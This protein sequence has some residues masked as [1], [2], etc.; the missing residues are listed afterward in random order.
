[1]VTQMQITINDL[2]LL[3]CQTRRMAIDH[4]FL[5]SFLVY[6][7]VGLHKEESLRQFINTHLNLFSERRQGVIIITFLI[8]IG[9]SIILGLTEFACN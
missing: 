9:I 3:F 8:T 4:L 5:I 6:L 1:M 7:V 2:G